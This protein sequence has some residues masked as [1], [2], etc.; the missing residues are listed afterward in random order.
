MQPRD[1]EHLPYLPDVTFRLGR[2]EEDAPPSIALLRACQ[3]IDASDPFSM[4][5][6]LPTI[7]EMTAY[8][9]SLDPQ[10]MLV[11]LAHE[12][13]IG[14][15]HTTWWEEEDGTWLFLHLGRV[16]PQ[17]RGHG[18]GTAFVHWAEHRLQASARTY[19]THGKGTCCLSDLKVHFCQDCC[20]LLAPETGRGDSG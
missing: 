3:Q 4:L 18:L 8:F 16:L 13:M 11:A 12:H 2:G 1:L 5:E 14:C 7:E 9:A 6:H 20:P 17:W 15:V 10:N 19:P